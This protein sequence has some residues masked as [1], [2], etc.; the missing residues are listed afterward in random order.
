MIRE[1]FD[2]SMIMFRERGVFPTI[3]KGIEK[4]DELWRKHIEELIEEGFLERKPKVRKPGSRETLKR[5]IIIGA[6]S[7]L[8]GHDLRLADPKS[9]ATGV[10]AIASQIPEDKK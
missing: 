3:L 2:T 8:I 4:I 6:G 7:F 9:I 10:I 1:K 5:I